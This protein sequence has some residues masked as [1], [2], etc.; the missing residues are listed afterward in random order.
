MESLI[1]QLAKEQDEIDKLTASVFKERME[2]ARETDHVTALAKVRKLRKIFGSYTSTY[3][4]ISPG[5][6]TIILLGSL[7]L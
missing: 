7:M 2:I 6:P 1:Q 3:M 4:A 5:N